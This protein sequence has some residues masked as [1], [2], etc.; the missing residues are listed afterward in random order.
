[1][2]KI[3]SIIIPT[4]NMEA[5]LPRCLDSLIIAEN[6]EKIEIWIVNDGSK[7]RSSEIGHEYEA[8][9]PGV[10]KVIDKPNGNYGSCIN[11]ALPKC[12]GKYVKVLDADDWFDTHNLNQFIKDL[13]VY[14]VDLVITDITNVDIVRNINTNHRINIDSHNKVVDFKEVVQYP[15]FLGIQMHFI[16]YRR[17]IFNEINYHQTEGISYTDQEWIFSPMSRVKQIV[18]LPYVVYNYLIGREGQ[19]VDSKIFRKSISHQI[20]SQESRF[21][22][23][24]KYK[25]TSN[26]HKTY[27]LTKIKNSISFIY[28][29][30]LN[31]SWELNIEDLIKYNSML[32]I[33]S[34][35]LYQLSD[36]FPIIAGWNYRFIHKWRSNVDFRISRMVKIGMLLCKLKN[37]LNRK[38]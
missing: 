4:Y 6:F 30:Y 11:A 32:K 19:T 38:K 15:D 22:S 8:K 23:F 3:L 14:D 35:E 37:K 20:K 16:T 25:N 21:N 13:S 12:T 34:P 28:L 1:M 26:E 5:L 31:P 29:Q 27:L 10:F 2:N 9:Y 33:L 24:E 36:D 18:A 7:D 17:T